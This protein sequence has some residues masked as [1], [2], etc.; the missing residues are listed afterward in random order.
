MSARRSLR[1]N[2]RVPNNPSM[3]GSSV[4]EAMTVNA[5]AI[6]VPT[7]TPYRKLTPSAN[8]PSIAMQTIIPANNTAR[9]DVSRDSTTASSPPRPRSSPWR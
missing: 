2:T 9:P 4:S 8:M 7:A 3:A 1:R 5:T 6:E